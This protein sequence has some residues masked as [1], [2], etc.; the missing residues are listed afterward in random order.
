MFKN[1]WKLIFR[2][3]NVW[4]AFLVIAFISS[5]LPH[6]QNVSYHMWL[7][8][9]VYFLLFLLSITILIKE[10]YNKD[11]FI[12]IALYLLVNSFS[13][14]SIFIGEEYLL[15]NNYTVYYFVHYKKL[16]LLFLFNFIIIFIAIK[17]LLINQRSRVHYLLTFIIITPIF[18]F[19]FYPY[20]TNSELIFTLGGKYRPDLYSR[21][22]LS[23]LLS[24]IF[25]CI[26][27]FILYK[28]DRILGEYINLLMACLSLFLITEIVGDLSE[29]YRYK[30]HSISQYI[31][32]INLIFLCI[33][34]FKKLCFLCSDY[35]Q[36]YE[37]L[38]KKKIKIGKIQ[39]QRNRNKTNA[40]LL[41]IL[42]LYVA[43]RKTYFLALILVAFLAFG[44]FEFPKFFTIN[45]ITILGTFSGLFLYANAL[46]KK[47]ALKKYTM[48]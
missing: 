9:S 33:I 38:I 10:V 7:N 40:L 36:F 39:I 34:L 19:S 42:K 13:F 14:I 24:L 11:L 46:Y 16:I 1:N 12:P 27:A 47:R 43:Q 21:I 6:W 48:P 29:I 15:G 31:I 28:K 32:S 23:H 35:G 17:Y 37:S 2:L 26:Y 44:Y 18:L 25:T 4:F 5:R 3:L 30:I 8:E 41:R 22:L 20:L 45:M